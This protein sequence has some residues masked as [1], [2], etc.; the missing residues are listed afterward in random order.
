MD[1]GKTIALTFLDDFNMNSDP[2][3]GPHTPGQL[4]GLAF[5]PRSKNYFAISDDRYDRDQPDWS[6]GH[7]RFYKINIPITQA[8]R[9][10]ADKW[11]VALSNKF[12]LTYL[13]DVD[14]K[15]MPFEKLDAEGIA[16][17]PNGNLAIASEGN[18][19][20]GAKA[21]GI[22]LPVTNPAVYEFTPKGKIVRSYPI[23]EYYYPVFAGK[24]PTQGV[25]NNNGFESL[26]RFGDF[27]YTA[28]EAPLVQDG[29][30]VTFQKGGY[31]RILKLVRNGDTTQP[32]QEFAY[33]VDRVPL[34]TSWGE[35]GTAKG[36]ENGVVELIALDEQT[37]LVLERAFIKDPY[38]RNHVRLYRAD[39]KRATNTLGQQ[40]LDAA[41]LKPVKKELLL[42]FEEILDQLE[43]NR[44]K[45]TE[46]GALE[47]YEGMTLVKLPN[48][49]LGIV[50]VSDNNHKVAH[51]RQSL[52]LFRIDGI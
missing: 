25:V 4:S 40:K 11:T 7:P 42:D 26:T 15:H 13:R 24:T 51:Q 43:P 49:S 52:L 46:Y 38:F 29:G 41:R 6:R 30:A 34:P 19:Q 9:R 27:L 18:A 50:F 31:A 47:N 23:P 12:R 22:E 8:G 5:D 2:M 36:G 20:V 39:L 37:L 35:P 17:L 3:W 44:L 48:G 16:L 45:G 32:V 1:V 28:T 14:G 33:P 21:N 10:F